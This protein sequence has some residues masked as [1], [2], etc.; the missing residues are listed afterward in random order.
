MPA[1]ELDYGVLKARDIREEFKQG[2][3][4][5]APPWFLGAERTGKGPRWKMPAACAG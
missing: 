4:T 1:E 5:N 3:D 2:S